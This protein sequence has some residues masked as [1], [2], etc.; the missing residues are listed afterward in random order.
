MLDRNA[1]S[2]TLVDRFALH[3]KP[4]AVQ[5]GAVQTGT[6]ETLMH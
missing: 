4:G 3:E 6:V 5:T 2:A 1:A